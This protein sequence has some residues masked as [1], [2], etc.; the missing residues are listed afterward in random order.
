MS[1]TA[2]A[3]GKLQWIRYTLS[4]APWAI[5]ATLSAGLSKYV[6]VILV[7]KF[8]GLATGGQFRL[9]LS[10]FGILALFTLVDS[11]KV[12]IKYLVQNES[13]VIRTLYLQ[14]LRWS[15]L[16]LATGLGLAAWNYTKGNEVWLPILV[17]AF[18]LPLAGPASL[19]IQ[20]N[21]AHKQFRLNAFYFVLKWGTI[22]LAMFALAFLQVN[23]VWLMSAYFV[24]GASFNL[25]YFSRQDE[26]YQPE[27]DNKPVYR[28]ASLQLSGSGVFPVLL[29]NADKFLVSYF[30]G[31]EVLGLYVIGVSTGRLFLNF[32]KPTLTIYFPLLVKHRFAP[33]LLIGG[34]AGLSVVGIVAALLMPYYFEYV[35]G[36]EYLVAYPF[37]SVIVSGLGI[38]FVGVI[39]Y[40]SAV[41]HKDS[42]AEIPAIT[43]VVTAILI[44]A[45]MLAALKFG[46]EYALLLCAASYPLREL[47]KIVM[48]RFLAARI[49]KGANAGVVQ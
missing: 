35:L 15:L 36:S 17:A 19:F 4:H 28:R 20:I 45:Y 48:I 12:A 34:F 7:A 3:G 32:V 6:I 2:E 5:I 23:P 38:Y 18:C 33:S 11:G 24:L 25:L 42:S 39:F 8:Y 22:T 40:Y 47:V 16:G 1:I 49:N 9:L 44:I 41:Y 46:G 26:V 14:R 29:D 31:L 13:G 37:A 27:N 43:N 30:F 10:I 21:Q